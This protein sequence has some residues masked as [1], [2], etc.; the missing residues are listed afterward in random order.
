VSDSHEEKVPKVAQNV[1]YDGRPLTL[2]SV[3]DG[4]TIETLRG[5]GIEIAIQAFKYGFEHPYRGRELSYIAAIPSE[6]FSL[7]YGAFPEIKNVG[8]L[9][10]KDA[11][12]LMKAIIANELDYYNWKDSLSDSLATTAHGHGFGRTTIGHSQI[13]LEGVKS[14]AS[15]F[16]KEVD[17]GKRTSNPL[18]KYLKMN[19]EQ[20]LERLSN[21]KELPLLIAANLAHNVGMYSRNHYPINQQTLGYGFNPDL[22]PQKPR[23]GHE[24]MPPQERLDQSE[25]ARNVMLWL[26]KVRAAEIEK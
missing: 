14:L 26:Q 11:T 21:Q 16:Q 12:Q 6:S 10:E 25:H 7:A 22:P 9:I 20:I 18:N 23:E 24:M 17:R 5:A 4:Q 2:T 8:K 3:P 15:D 1:E 19:N 13:S